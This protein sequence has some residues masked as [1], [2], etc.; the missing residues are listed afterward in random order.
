MMFCIRNDLRYFF[1]KPVLKLPDTFHNQKECVEFEK[2]INVVAEYTVKSMRFKILRWF[3][4]LE[5]N[6]NST[7][8][9]K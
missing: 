9:L 6:V 4:F 8:L 2:H 7:N 1:F 3:A 5:L